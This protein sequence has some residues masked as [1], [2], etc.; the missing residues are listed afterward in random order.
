MSEHTLAA[1][2]AR[3]TRAFAAAGL[4]SP[5]CDARLLVQAAAEVRALE[6]TLQPDAP[7]SAQAQA[8]L[9]DWER[10][11]LA[12]EPVTRIL[13]Q[14]GFWTFDLTV[15]PDVL[16]PRPDS[17]TLVEACLR[18]LSARG[19]ARSPPLRIL[20]VGTG[21]GALLAALLREH[22]TATG[23]G[24][25]VSPTAVA[26]AR[27]NLAALG[28]AERAQVRLT[29][30]R[31]LAEETFDLV[32]SNP[33]YVAAHEIDALDPEVR[34]YDPRLALDGGPDGLDAYR[35]LAQL[36]PRWLVADGIAAFEIGAT[37]AAEVTALMQAAGLELLAVAQD[38]AGH[39]RAV[40]VRKR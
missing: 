1:A 33:P 19:R 8:R 22:P 35:S 37:Q 40:I 5:A 32:V 36:T 7:L 24:V 10:R 30:W 11:R 29:D 16:D 18:A 28:L 3:L 23:V 9:V 26:L 4:D 6:L 17:E 14:R 20:D 38:M 25:D 34:L 13:G 39:D 31:T 27:S 15:A 21:S 12:R 2:V